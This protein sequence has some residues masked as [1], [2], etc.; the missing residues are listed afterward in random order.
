M[1]PLTVSTSRLVDTLYQLV[2]PMFL[3]RCTARLISSYLDRKSLDRGIVIAL[4]E[5]SGLN[6]LSIP[7]ETVTKIRLSFLQ[8]RNLCLHIRTF[9]FS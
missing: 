7:Y 5:K 2:D 1:V 3:N 9:Y 8:S 6:N 4:I